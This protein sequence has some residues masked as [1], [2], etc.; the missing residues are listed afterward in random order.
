LQHRLLQHRLLQHRLLQHRLLQHRLLQHRLLQL[1]ACGK[2]F[3][4]SRLRGL[5]HMSA[6][7]PLALSL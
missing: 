1:C 7:S 6:T 4:G 2:D 3:K 5:L